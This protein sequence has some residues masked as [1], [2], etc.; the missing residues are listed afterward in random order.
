M[1]FDPQREAYFVMRSKDVRLV[2]GD[3]MDICVLMSKLIMGIFAAVSNLIYVKFVFASTINQ[4][5]QVLIILQF[6]M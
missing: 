4:N 2:E 1:G 5:Y 3:M 6:I